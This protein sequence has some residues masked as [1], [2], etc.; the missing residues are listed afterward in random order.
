[1]PS[2]SFNGM[3]RQWDAGIVWQSLLDEKL[4]LTLL[5]PDFLLRNCHYCLNSYCSLKAKLRSTYVVWNIFGHNSLYYK[6][7]HSRR[8]SDKTNPCKSDL[9]SFSHLAHR[10]INSLW[11]GRMDLWV[12]RGE[13][14]YLFPIAF[15]TIINWP[16]LFENADFS[17]DAHIKLATTGK[18]FFETQFTN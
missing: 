3:Q 5:K 11:S 1:M 18:L 10:F 8:A 17:D 4:G 7:T 14:N 2:I 13:E 12:W 16:F 9:T 6:Q 15:W